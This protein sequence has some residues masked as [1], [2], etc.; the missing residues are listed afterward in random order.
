[1]LSAFSKIWLGINLIKE[2][3]FCI[4][5]READKSCPPKL[6]YVSLSSPNQVATWEEDAG[7]KVWG[8]VIVDLGHD[9]AP[10]S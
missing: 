4:S 2:C 7:Y 8:E 1:M 5:Y 6:G 3:S 9:N 10:D